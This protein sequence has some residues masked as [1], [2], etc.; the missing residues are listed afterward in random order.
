VYG[1]N[2]FTQILPAS[3]QGKILSGKFDNNFKLKGRQQTITGRYNF[4]D[5]WRDIPTVADAIFSAIR[6]R[7]RTQN[8]S[9][10][11]NSRVNSPAASTGIFNQVRLSYG[12]TRLNFQSLQD[13]TFL[14]K[15]DTLPNEPFLLNAPLILNSTLPR[16][17]TSTNFGANLG[18][19]L[20]T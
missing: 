3:G 19:V 16:V 4:T 14:R 1:A 8:F 18:P 9:F 13:Q 6:S 7:V 10:F 2:T 17:I 20:Y 5:D 15:S 11:L 12:R